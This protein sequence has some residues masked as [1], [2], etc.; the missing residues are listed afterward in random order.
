MKLI[1][2][3]ILCILIVIIVIKCKKDEPLVNITDNKFINALIKSGVD[4]DG[5]GKIS[6]AEAEEIISL[7]IN[8][9]SIS[10]MTGIENFVNLETLIC[11]GNQ[12]TALNI[13]NNTSLKYL[14]CRDNQL[15]ALNVSQNIALDTLI[16]RENELTNLDA[17]DNIN[18]KYLDCGV[19]HELRTLDVSNCSALI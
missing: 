9:D 13:T 5:D 15:I 18:L 17:S 2:R 14:N 1:I 12:L 11:F 16:C 7:D 10:D 4:T 19:N 8:S 6:Y 3:S